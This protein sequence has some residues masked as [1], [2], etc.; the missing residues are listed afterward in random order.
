M[1]KKRKKERQQQESAEVSFKSKLADLLEIPEELID[2]VPKITLTSNRRL[3]IQNY[4][5]M[6]EYDRQ[7]IRINTKIGVVKI[8]GKKLDVENITSEEVAVIGNITG[9]SFVV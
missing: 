5:G 2:D 9:L 1:S 4:T 3:L 7:I 8:E 6:L